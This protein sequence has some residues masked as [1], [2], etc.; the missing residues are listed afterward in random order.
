MHNPLRHS[1]RVLL[2]YR[3]YTGFALIGLSVAIT[4][5]WFIANYLRASSKRVCGSIK[6]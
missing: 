5:V 3:L 6:G 2:K 4:S 1:L